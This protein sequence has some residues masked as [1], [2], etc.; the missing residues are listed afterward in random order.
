MLS[1]FVHTILTS[2][3]QALF[4]QNVLYDSKI[5]YQVPRMFYVKFHCTQFN[6]NDLSMTFLLYVTT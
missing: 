6:S 4:G 3:F 1:K 5:N 2:R